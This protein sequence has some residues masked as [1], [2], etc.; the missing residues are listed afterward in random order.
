MDRILK[1][2]KKELA[3]GQNIE[4]SE[5]R[6]WPKGFICPCTGVKYHNIQ[7]CLCSRSQVSVY[8]WS[9][10]FSHE[11]FAAVLI[12]TAVTI[13]SW[14]SSISSASLAASFANLSTISLPAIAACPGVHDMSISIPSCLKLSISFFILLIVPRYDD[15][16][17]PSVSNPTADWLSQKIFTL[18]IF[19]FFVA[20]WIKHQAIS[21]AT[22]SPKSVDASLDTGFLSSTDSSCPGRKIQAPA[23][24]GPGFCLHDPSV[25]INTVS[26]PLLSICSSIIFLLSSSWI[27][28]LFLDDPRLFQYSG[29]F[30]VG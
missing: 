18:P 19:L 26:T 12:S 9:S 27:F 11:T 21:I 16:F 28:V 5:K 8:H 14:F 10:G 1:I 23:P 25:K 4:D 15:G 20:F 7:T 2:L 22:N 3:N 30:S 13:L 24:H 17:Q 29:L 6:K